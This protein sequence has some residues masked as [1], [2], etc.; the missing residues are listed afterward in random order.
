MTL[1]SDAVISFISIIV[2]AI[3]GIILY[4][5]NQRQKE[6]IDSMTKVIDSMSKMNQLFDPVKIGEYLRLMTEKVKI[7]E[8][9]NHYE[10]LNEATLANQKLVDQEIAKTFEFSKELYLDVNKDFGA[11]FEELIS[12]PIGIMLRMNAA[13]REAH[14]KHYPKSGFFI[15]TTLDGIEK[16]HIKP[17]NIPDVAGHT[18]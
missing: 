13:E 18:P 10:K 1:T 8:E 15:K 5:Q 12:I 11:A 14:L 17:N 6:L 2:T 7:E 9:K 3:V 16:G 4:T